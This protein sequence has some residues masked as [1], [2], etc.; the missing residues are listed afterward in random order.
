MKSLL[1]LF[2]SGCLSQYE[3]KN[4]LIY[5]S[6]SKSEYRVLPRQVNDTFTFSFTDGD[7]GDLGYEYHNYRHT[8]NGDFKLV[9]VS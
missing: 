8:D 7:Y 4:Q 2:I 1:E 9:K 6:I 3:T 5:D